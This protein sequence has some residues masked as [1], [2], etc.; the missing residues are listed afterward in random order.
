MNDGSYEYILQLY[1]GKS[2]HWHT[3]CSM[4]I[5]VGISMELFCTIHMSCF[6]LLSLEHANMCGCD[7]LLD[8]LNVRTLVI[9]YFYDGFNGSILVLHFIGKPCRVLLYLLYLVV[10][11]MQRCML[12]EGT[13]R[14]T[15]D[16]FSIFL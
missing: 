12:G 8:Y 11:I 10:A 13:N 14:A 4:S 16:A 7:C 5:K 2:P 9:L 15:H 6:I 1:V 3:I